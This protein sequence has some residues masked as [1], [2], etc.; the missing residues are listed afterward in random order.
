[1][2]IEILLILVVLLLIILV[3]LVLKSGKI[4]PI[5]IESAIS[6]VWM[7]SGLDEKVGEITTHARDIR[8]S[9]RSI[10]QM[11]RVPKER[12]S[13]GEI[14]LETILSDQLSP[15]MFG[16]RERILDGKIPDSYIKSTVGLI[17]IDSKFPLDN[18]EKMAD[19]TDV[20]EKEILKKQFIR[21]VQGH[22][23]KISADYVCPEKGSAEFAF[24]YIPS[25][26]VYYFLLTEA[27]HMLREFTKKGVQVVSPLTISHKIEL[28]KTGIHA[29]KLS[30][31][32]ELVKSNIIKLS[33]QFEDI[34]IIWKV[35]YETHLRNA[36]KK[37]DELDQSYKKL[38]D[39]FN[40]ISE[41]SEDSKMN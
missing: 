23:N 21:D 34:D 39:E 28:I 10:E 41:F 9:H 1:M 40:R 32:A 22:L 11:L 20:K 4:E 29:K 16:I 14:S 17:C 12:A 15:D 13:F 31:E 24:A 8:D 36:G 18:Y 37:A 27:Y 38:R 30:N 35:F 5:T 19:T 6:R 3:F 33:R 26:G 7:E 25:E 2:I